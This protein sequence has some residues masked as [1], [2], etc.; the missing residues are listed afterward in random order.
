MMRRPP[1]STLFPYTTLFRSICVRT[2]EILASQA[3]GTV[4]LVDA[5][6]RAPSLHEYFG[7]RNEKGLA[8][9]TLECGPIQEFAQKLSPANL[10][11][12]PSGYG[13][14]QLHLSKTAEGLRARMEELRN[15]IGRA[16]V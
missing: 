16:H 8:E 5:D 2:G 10:W 14:S 3:A 11:L 12:V 13:A 7:V 1:R 6:F 9:A 4:C 15:E